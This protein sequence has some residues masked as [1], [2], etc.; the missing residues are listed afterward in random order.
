MISV[1]PLI[2]I[3]LAALAPLAAIIGGVMLWKRWK[4]WSPGM[5]RGV[6]SVVTVVVCALVLLLYCKGFVGSSAARVR[7]DFSLVLPK[8]VSHVRCDGPFTLTWFWDAAALASFKMDRADVPKLLAQ[9]RRTDITNYDATE[10]PELDAFAG[11]SG[12]KLLLHYTGISKDGNVARMKVWELDATSVEVCI[13][14]Y[15]N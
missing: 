8:S 4:K 5:R 7:L 3:V 1:I 2:V 14:T 15:W 13:F 11:A 9:F 12:K 6:P 10:W